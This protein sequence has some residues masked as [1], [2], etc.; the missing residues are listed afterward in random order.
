MFIAYVGKIL[1]EHFP[2]LYKRITRFITNTKRNNY[3]FISDSLGGS[4]KDYISK[5]VMNEKLKNLKLHLDKYSQRTIDVIYQRILNYPEEKYKQILIPKKNNI[6]GGLLEEEKTAFNAKKIKKEQKINFKTS[7]M[8]TSV[9]KFYHGI[10]FLPKNVQKYINEKDFIDIGAYIGDSAVALRK[11]NYKKIYSIEMSRQSIF[12]YKKNMKL[13]SI[14]EE[15]YKII[16]CAVAKQDGLP[17]IRIID[18]GSAGLS[19]KR[20]DS[21]KSKNIIIEQKTLSLIIKE[22]NIIPGFVK[23]DIEGMAMDC[24]IGGINAIKKARPV[25]SIAIYHNP[26]EFFEVKPF[27][28]SQL[29]N[30]TFLIRKLSNQ[31]YNNNCHSEIIL[32]AFPNETR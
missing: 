27:L 1:R 10:I 14:N 29:S 18:S 6:I 26:I 19:L 9:F 12:E 30:Y 21:S 11:Y 16:N 20:T 17:P 28:E 3:I 4:F 25:L 5:N 7:L 31:I 8:E 2:Q 32:I 22:N 15:K 23:M 24:L 13:N